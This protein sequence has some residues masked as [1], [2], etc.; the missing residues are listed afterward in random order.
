MTTSAFEFCRC[1]H[2]DRYHYATGDCFTDGCD[3]VEFSGI[4][5]FEHANVP[6]NKKPGRPAAPKA[7][8]LTPECGAEVAVRGICRACYWYARNEVRKGRATWEQLEAA[9]RTKPPSPRRIGV[10]F[11]SGWFRD[12]AQKR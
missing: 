9:G 7:V 3:C 10:T 8:C 2:L 11:R 6:S 12:M 1:N 5:R 4:G